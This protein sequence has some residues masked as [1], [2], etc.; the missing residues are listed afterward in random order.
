M[1]SIACQMLLHYFR[2]LF[3][4]YLVDVLCISPVDMINVLSRHRIIG[5]VIM[6]CALLLRRM[7]FFQH[8]LDFGLIATFRGNMLFSRTS[9][10]TGFRSRCIAAKHFDARALG[11]F[12]DDK[13]S[14]SIFTIPGQ[15]RIS[16]TFLLATFALR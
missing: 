9:F 15:Q 3:N 2:R 8:T 11:G 5:T 16:Q 10:S 1:L 13:S 4:R 12:S 6:G 14:S 7:K